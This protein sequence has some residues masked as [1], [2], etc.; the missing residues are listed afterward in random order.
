[1][2]KEAVVT[3][4]ALSI[5]LVLSGVTVVEGGRE[6]QN[7]QSLMGEYISHTNLIELCQ[8]NAARAGHD[9]QHVLRHEMVHAVQ[10]NLNLTRAA[11]PE[12]LLTWLVRGYLT[13]SEVMTVLV[14]YDEKDIDQEF[15]ARLLALLPN[16]LIGS[17]LWTSEQ[18]QRIVSGQRMLAAP[19]E[20]L[21]VQA[22][23]WDYPY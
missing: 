6:C 12:P 20:I 21:P 3:D 4:V 5:F 22:I 1:M 15:E 14:M 9:L 11:I 16:W 7:D 18:H 8:S 19:W 10:E 17:L 13:D 23:A 2:V